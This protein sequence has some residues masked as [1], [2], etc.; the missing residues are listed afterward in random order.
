MQL[1]S[2]LYKW[3]N[4]GPERLS[5]LAKVAQP[6]RVKYGEREVLPS[7]GE[8][9]WCLHD[10]HAW[11][12]PLGTNFKL[13]R[14]WSWMKVRVYVLEGKLIFSKSMHWYKVGP[15]TQTQTHTHTH[16]HTGPLWFILF[17][18]VSSVES[19]YK[20]CLEKIFY[21]KISKFGVQKCFNWSHH[22]YLNSY[23]SNPLW[24]YFWTRKDSKP[25]C[26]LKNF[27]TFLLPSRWLP[28]PN[29]HLPG[30]EQAHAKSSQH[31]SLLSH[32]QLAGNQRKPTLSP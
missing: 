23:V 30:K 12:T 15:C 7:L 21:R 3:R 27:C 4:W 14:L 24:A 17:L 9:S 20:N 25:K 16:T 6:T 2:L 22:F 26:F 28:D 32:A 5:N 8:S 10:S 19:D 18:V 13:Q 1:P 31:W 11:F 29:T